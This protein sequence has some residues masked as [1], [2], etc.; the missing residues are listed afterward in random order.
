MHKIFM[1]DSD[2]CEVG[3][4]RASLDPDL[5]VPCRA[6]S[7][8]TRLSGSTTSVDPAGLER[9]YGLQLIV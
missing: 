2:N 9:E 4:G 5:E 6:Q 8:A 3:I 7:T 1:S